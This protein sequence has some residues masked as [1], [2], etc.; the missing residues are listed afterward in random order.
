[1]ANELTRRSKQRAMHL[2]MNVLFLSIVV[3]LT[4]CTTLQEISPQDVTAIENGLKPGDRLS[5]STKQGG[6]VEIEVTEIQSDRI[7]GQGEQVM[8][9]DIAKMER[10]QY[11]VRKTTALSGLLIGIAISPPAGLAVALLSL[12][13]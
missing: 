13:L 3:L 12:L 4:S 2:G 10:K 1:M 5:I 8:V 6:R 11:S 7:V 9:D